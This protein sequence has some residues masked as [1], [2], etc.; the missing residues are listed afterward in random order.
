MELLA[1][2]SV[3]FAQILT[4]EALQ[5][6]EKL[7][8]EFGSRRRGLLEKRIERQAAIDAGEFP[9]FL[10][11]TK[12]IREDNWKVGSIPDD[13]QN[14]RV[15]ITGPTDRKMMI[16]ALNSGASVFMADFED[17]NSPTWDNLLQGHINLCDAIDGSISFQN[18][19]GNEYRLDPQVAVLN[20][21]PR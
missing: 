18:P 20:V 11:S 17:A 15:E 1:K 14:R 3:E 8:R 4:P 9:D 7:E 16:N 13:M 21:R 12:H 6:I 19:G 10:S 2:P 5:F